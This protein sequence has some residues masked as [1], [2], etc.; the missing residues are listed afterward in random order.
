MALSWVAAWQDRTPGEPKATMSSTL[1]VAHDS[2]NG[3]IPLQKHSG[4]VGYVESALNGEVG[5]ICWYSWYVR[6]YWEEHYQYTNKEG[7]HRG[8]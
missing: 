4:D 6:E 3:T 5:V 7:N 8:G 2:P 1:G